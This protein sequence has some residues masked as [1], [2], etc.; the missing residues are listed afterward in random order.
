MNRLI[1]MRH[2]KTEAWHEGIDDH[3]R[4]LIARGHTDAT[5]IGQELSSMGWVPGTAL[6]STARRARETWGRASAGWPAVNLQFDETLYL[7]AP[8]T[9]ESV[10]SSM[11]TPRGTLLVIGH[12]PGIHEFA[13]IL[14]RQAGHQNDYAMSRLFEKFPTGCVALFDAGEERSWHPSAFRLVDVIRPKDLSQST[15]PDDD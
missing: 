3:G 12:N 11:D 7:A 8:Q 4:A 1:L 10:L 15:E 2:A 5:A 6:V 13:C 9:L 14:A